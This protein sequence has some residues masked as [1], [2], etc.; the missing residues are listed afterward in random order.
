M[1]V[2]FFISIAGSF[3]DCIIKPIGRPIG[4][5]FGYILYYKENLAK[6]KADVQNLEG[7]KDIVQHTVR[8]AERKG[9][10]IENIVHNWQNTV[11]NIIAEAN[12]LI[13]TEDPA[14]AQCFMGHFPNM[15]TRYK[16][17][18]NMKMMSQKISQVLAE[19]KFDRI[20][21]RAASQVTVPPF[22]RGYEALDSR[23]SMLND[24]MSELKNPKIF[25][26]AVYGMGGV[27]K[28]TLMKE[29]AW[30]VEN[31]G[32]FDA[33]VMATIPKPP[34][35]EQIQGQIAD[36]L[37]MK[38]NTETKEGRAMQ[39]RARIIKEKSIL[40]ILDDIWGKLDLTE[41]GIPFGEDHTGC[42]LVVTSRFLNVLNSNIDIQK[43][44][45]V[46]GLR[47]KDSWKL[48]EKM[49]GDAVQDFNIKPIAREVARQCAGLPLLIVTVA[50]ALRK[51]DVSY[52][53][54][55]LIKK[56]YYK[57]KFTLFWY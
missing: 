56:G 18:R 12:K 6:L 55:A 31:D 39:L 48:F 46:E 29:L 23:T 51:K 7:N 27:G 34:D 24:T 19:G 11:D 8:E 47:E 9:E 44:F 57:R 15:C 5:Q 42:K 37:G 28:T 2:E 4:Q 21:Y 43:E 25:I 1:A 20:S 36:A 49:A 22:S 53:K 54:V 33:V 16:L 35:F 41:V 30:Q 14:K 26:I 40:I 10:E 32:S 52:W 45:R 13:H 3:A 38:F 50:K 17:S